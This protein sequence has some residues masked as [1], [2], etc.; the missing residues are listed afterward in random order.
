MV[1]LR[2]F[3]RLG[4]G[5]KRFY[6]ACDCGA[7]VVR[8]QSNLRSGNTKSCGCLSTDL[9]DAQAAKFLGRAEAIAETMAWLKELGHEDLARALSSRA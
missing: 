3:V 8:Q 6:L 5:I 9:L 4:D 7:T 1:V 2:P